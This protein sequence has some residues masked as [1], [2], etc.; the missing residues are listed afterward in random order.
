MPLSIAVSMSL[1]SMFHL[2]IGCLMQA[3]VSIPIHP[4]HVSVPVGVPVSVGVSVG[5]RQV[6]SCC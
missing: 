2:L 1:I 3:L 5:A 4:T 6:C